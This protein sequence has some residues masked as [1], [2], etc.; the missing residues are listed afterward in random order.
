MRPVSIVGAAQIPIQAAT[1]QGLRQLGSQVVRGAMERAGVERVDALFASNMLGDELQGQ[2]HIAALIADEAGLA[3]IEALQ[4]QAATASGSAAL[5]MGY[6]AVGSG[7]ADLAVVVGVEKMSEG[8]ATP[9]ISKALDAKEVEDGATLISKNAD[10]MRLYRKRYDVPEDG[11]VNFP[12]VAHHNARNN[13]NALFKDMIVKPRTVMKSRMVHDPLRL[14]DCS[15]ICDGAAAIVLSPAEEARTHSPHPVRILSSSV[16][17]DRFRV[18]D[19]PNPLWLEAAQQSAAKAYRQAN[20]HREDIDFFEVHDA[21]SIM[22][23]MLLEAAGFADQGQGWRLAEEKRI[24]LRGDIP[25]TTMG[26]LKARGHPIGATALYQASEIVLQ[27]T[28]RAGKN[29]VRGAEIG[30][31]QSVGGAGSTVI[32]H[33]L[34][35]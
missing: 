12:V 19:R 24:A 14:L 33:I 7:E 25:I 15:P 35:V 17:T 30:M 26:G 4:V 5:R 8:L 20:V 10:L 13:P 18:G 3:G 21:F 29:Q 11:F 28:G 23:C 32:T 27:L 22:A 34:G 9:A 6:L 16:A 1:H 31:M 2:K